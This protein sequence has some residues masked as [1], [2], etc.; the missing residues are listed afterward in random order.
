MYKIV[1]LRR[2]E[3]RI[4]VTARDFVIAEFFVKDWNRDIV[5]EAL[6]AIAM[7]LITDLV[8]EE[9]GER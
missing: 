2:E 5:R 9:E 3:G 6:V 8:Y 7:R 4:Q 1:Q